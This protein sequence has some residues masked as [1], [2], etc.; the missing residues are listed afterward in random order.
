MVEQ[1]LQ[2]DEIVIEHDD[3]NGF[4]QL[5]SGSFEAAGEDVQEVLAVDDQLALTKSYPGHYR[6]RAFETPF[7]QKGLFDGVIDATV[8]EHGGFPPTTIIRSD[9]VWG[10]HVRWATSGTLV[11][12]ICGKWCLQVHLESIGPGPELRLPRK[13]VHIPLD[14]CG[15]HKYPYTVHYKYH[16]DIPAGTITPAHCGIPYKL[17]TSLTYIDYCGKPGPIAGYVEGPIMQFIRV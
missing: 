2:S 7:R 11:R 4:D 16:L 17:V 5:E 3:G 8:H 9:Q 1:N 14:P 13:P 10:V 15:K 6:K 12:M